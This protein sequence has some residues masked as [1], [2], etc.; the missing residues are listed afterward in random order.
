MVP[1]NDK[2]YDRK[3]N[4]KMKVKAIYTILSQKLRDGEVLLFLN[5]LSLSAP[6]TKDARA[7]PLN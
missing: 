4:K 6:K 1:R 5:S 7:A 2:N 3:V